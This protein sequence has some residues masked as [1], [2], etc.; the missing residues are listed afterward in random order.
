MLVSLKLLKKYVNL[1][2]LSAKDVAN[3]LTFAGIEVEDVICFATGT[4]LVIGEIIECV[5]HPDSD[6]LHV[7]KVNLGP[8]YGVE[9][10]VCGA[11]NARVGLKVIVAR[12]GAKLKEVEIKKGIIRGIESN[13]MC[14]SLLELG[15]DK[16]YLSEK[17]IS[18]IEE[19]DINAPVGKE[20]VLS[21]LH[22]DD[23]V[24]DV[25]ILANRPDL[26]SIYNLAKEISAIFDRPIN[27]PSYKDETSFTSNAHIAIE[28]D[29]C[30]QFA[31]K[32]VKGIK[33]KESPE[34]IKQILHS[35]GIRSIDN[36]VDI[37]NLVML[38]TGQP[39]HMYDADK[40]EK[41]EIIVRS[42][43]EEDFVALDDKTYHII[44]NDI[45]MTSSGKTM[46]LGGV[47]GSKACEVDEST[48][49]LYIECASFSSKAI[50]HT[51]AR[52]GLS[53]ESST[54]YVKGTNHFQS[55]D[56]LSLA[57]H[58]L[59]EYAEAKEFSKTIEIQKETYKEQK[60]ET[61]VDKINN[62]LGTNFSTKEI[63]DVLERLYFKIDMNGDGRFI[64]TVPSFRLDISG[65]ADLS[66]EVIRILGFNHVK[67][68]LP[69][70][71]TT[72]GA[73]S[74]PQ[75]R[76][77]LIRDF[78]VD[79]GLDECLT[80]SLIS[81]KEKD[82][83][84]LLN[85]EEHYVIKNPLTEDHEAFRTHILHSLLEVASYNINRQNKNLALFETGAMMSKTSQSE[86]LA[87][88]LTGEESL[89]GLLVETPYTF[90]HLKG[91]VEAIFSLLGV[92]K[93]RYKINKLNSHL[94]EL[95]PNRSAEILFQNQLIGIFGELHP[96]KYNEYDL[97]KNRCVVLEMN[98][99]PLLEIKTSISK[100]SP[101][102]K[103]PV[104]TRDIALVIDKNVP[105]SDIIKCI[106]MNGKGLITNAEVFDVYEG[107]N[108]AIDKK[109]I[110]ISVTYASDHTLTDKEISD[111]EE[112]VKYE[113]ARLYKIEF[114]V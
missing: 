22:L 81:Q 37:G 13:G 62:R 12:V 52:L 10:I 9:Q 103:F 73:L 29:L 43:I 94:D 63:K 36:I 60:I 55:E 75:K 72:V 44:P 8:K 26:L 54:R 65:D 27:I 91:L 56:V 7:L 96:N 68:I 109:S 28:T 95:H 17:Q 48:K 79:K 66:E 11:P 87:I 70:L 84:N 3:G 21:Y 114:R 38:L 104:V 39:L 102:S 106:K 61:S 51:S 20:E 93:S 1:D 88:V 78:L 112:R 50:R 74:L 57:I 82:K 85:N 59:K 58:L 101:I 49:R 15:V 64:A 92:E 34:W 40:L 105:S 41:E 14:C 46:C 67:S 6:H 76:L 31:L 35:S 47:M 5:N 77:R 32:E 24:L 107:E 4:N 83:F 23:E 108:I 97:G 111:V 2:G 16:K 42:D 110:A 18:G 19:L 89:Q 90:F 71:D 33:I 80:Y 99:T 53:S 30:S 45:C 86:H 100:M 25:I 69:R 113:L 98:L